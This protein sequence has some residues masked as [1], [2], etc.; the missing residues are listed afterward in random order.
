VTR[1]PVADASGASEGAEAG[2]WAGERRGLTIGLVLTITLVAFE[3]LAIATVMPTVQDDL[4]GLALY[5]WVFSGFFLAS[6]L[7]IVL[8][9]Q[10]ADQRGL[11]FPFAAGLVLFAAGLVV[12]GAAGSME[13]L[14][15]GR[16][17]QGFGAGAIPAVAY[18]AIGRGYPAALRPR[19]F[20]TVST[21]W[22]VPGLIGPG[23]AAVVEDAWSWRLVFLGLLPVVAVAAT[24]AVPALRAL[25]GATARSDGDLDPADGAHD[26][27]VLGSV[28]VAP[29][30]SL[31]GV[32]LP[33]PA[34]PDLVQPGIATTDVAR[35][36]P[37]QPGI[38]TTDAIRPD[39]VQPGIA[40]TDVAR[41]GSALPDAARPDVGLPDLVSAGG[42]PSPVD[43]VPVPDGRPSTDDRR[44][45]GRVL[46]LVLGVGAV[47]AGTT[48]APPV[49]AVVLVAAGL[50]LAGW[51]FVG[52]VPRGTLRLAPGVP[53]TVGVRGILTCAFFSA[54]AYV[55]LA[56]VDGRGAATWVAGA[57]LSVG[58]VVWAS[59]S[60]VQARV[61]D[62]MG[63]RRLVVIGFVLIAG[64]VG[65]M[66]AVSLGLP[67][68]F[69]LLA[70]GIGGLGMGLSYAPLSVTVLAAAKAGEEGSASAAIQLSD[71]LGVAVGTGLGGSIVALGDARGWEVSSA[72]ALVFVASLVVTVL[73]GLAA[74]R[75]PDRVPDQA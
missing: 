69:G 23:I 73:G 71:T 7:G 31:D 2:L 49:L 72:T 1:L 28:P 38:A 42:V 11:A 8:A 21:A 12:G 59:G 47:L 66:L 10:L 44:R 19:M 62:R 52:L 4:G 57:A 36:D 40:T 33:E 56:I 24:M 75:L 16:I 13:V 5:G 35:P 20:A 65:L 45:L 63:P 51:A 15:L 55:S 61:L 60:W 58:S 70:W 26:G 27:R 6:L 53:A 17:A 67:V 41:P 18:A 39:L 30:E 9:G 43:A 46:L 34:R 74:L 14:V 50:P 22:V 37:V 25:D 48:D 68:G 54:D 64:A 3:A 32:S 29:G